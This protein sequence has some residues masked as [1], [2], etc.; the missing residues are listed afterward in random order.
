MSKFGMFGRSVPA[1]AK[2]TDAGNFFSIQL[3][4][5]DKA[6]GQFRANRFPQIL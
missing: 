1:F 2:K 6:P 3:Q 4:K 5:W